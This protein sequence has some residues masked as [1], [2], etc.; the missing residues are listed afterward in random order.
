MSNK[1]NHLA[2]IMDGNARWAEAKGISKIEGHKAG[3]EAAKE[4]L[5][6]A[7]EFGIKTI[8]LY[9]FSSENWARPKDEVDYLMSLLKFYI[10]REGANLSKNKIRMRVIGD[11]TRLS[12]DV[13]EQI[14]KIEQNTKDNDEF[15]LNIALSYG[16]RQEI[17]RATLNFAEDYKNGKVG[18]DTIDFNKYLYTSGLPDPD[19]LI[20]TGGDFRLSNFL[21]WQCAY[22]ELYFTKTLWPDFNKAELAKAVEE[23]SSRERRFG[24]R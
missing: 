24:G 7:P 1:I 10:N 13:K 18:G 19:L 12:N 22:T 15:N 2:I 11:R 6:F 8:T 20:R 4:L 16:S 14:E 21:L 9:A 23:F 3:A 5:N 17:E